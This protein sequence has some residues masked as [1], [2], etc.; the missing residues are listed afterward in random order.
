V[1]EIVTL[2]HFN[3]IETLA[4]RIA[5]A[6]LADPRVEAARI[7]I[8]KPDIVAGCAEVGIAIERRRSSS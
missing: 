8:A 1:R 2:R 3:L 4:E 5:E 6:C 7:A